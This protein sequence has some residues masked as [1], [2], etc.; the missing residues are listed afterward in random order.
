MLVAG[1]VRQQSYDYYETQ[2]LRHVILA[3]QDVE[4]DHRDHEFTDWDA[5]E[6]ELKAFMAD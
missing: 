2:I 4:L 3:G 1:A 5:L 6:G